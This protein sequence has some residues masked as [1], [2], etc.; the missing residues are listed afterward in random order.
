MSTHQNDFNNPRL[1]TLYK[2]GKVPGELLR[3]LFGIL[4]EAI[5]QKIDEINDA[6]P[7]Q[8]WDVMVRHPHSLKSSYANLGLDQLADAWR[9]IESLGKERNMEK[10]QVK[11][12]Q[13]LMTNEV[14]LRQIKE[15]ALN[16]PLWY[17]K[18]KL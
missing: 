8:N 18:L 17:S 5:P 7:S 4:A 2:S 9:E 1:Q 3:S 16:F 11:Y 14:A 10:Y 13:A 12:A 6:I 15:A